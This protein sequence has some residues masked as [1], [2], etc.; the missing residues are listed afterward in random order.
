V[1]YPQPPAQP[2][3]A[4][5]P[6]VPPAYGPPPGWTEPAAYPPAAGNP[7]QAPAQSYATQPPAQGYA[8]QP[9]APGYLWQPPAQ[10]YAAQG[11]AQ[12]YAPQAPA[13]AYPWQPPGQPYATQAPPQAYPAQAPVHGY[14][15]QSASGQLQML[16]CRLCGSV[17]AVNTTFRGHQG[18]IVLMRFLSYKG[19]F[20]RDCGLGTFRHMTSRTLVQGWYSYGSLVAA[21]ITILVNLV[22]RSKVAK[23]APPQPNPYGPSRAPMDPGKPLLARPMAWAGLAIPFVILIILIAAASSN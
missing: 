6:A 21:P 19:P 15:G 9:P 18:M 16:S 7:T 13:Q 8:T 3:G 17:P 2:H 22:R 1:S 23:L 5:A 12:S 4:P 10:G 11:P 20:C 14:P